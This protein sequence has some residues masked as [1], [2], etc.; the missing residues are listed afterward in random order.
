[1]HSLPQTRSTKIMSTSSFSIVDTPDYKSDD[2]YVPDSFKHI[3]AEAGA[4]LEKALSAEDLALEQQQ[5]EAQQLEEKGTN[6]N[7]QNGIQD[8]KQDKKPTGVLSETRDC[9]YSR[10][11][12][13]TPDS[14]ILMDTY[15][16][17]PSM[18]MSM[19][20]MNDTSSISIDTS[21]NNNSNHR[22]KSRMSKQTPMPFQSPASDIDGPYDV[23]LGSACR[24]NPANLYN[25]NY[26]A[27]M[28]AMDDQ[29][30]VCPDHEDDCLCHLQFKF[31]PMNL[32]ERL[33]GVKVDDIE[34]VVGVEAQAMERASRNDNLSF[35]S[36][37]EVKEE[38]EMEEK[39]EANDDDFLPEASESP[40]VALSIDADLSF[41][42]SGNDDDDNDD[43]KDDNDNILYGSS[44]EEDFEEFL[45]NNHRSSI[46]SGT[47]MSMDGA[48][49]RKSGAFGKAKEKHA[50]APALAVESAVRVASAVAP[51]K[52]K[53]ISRKGNN[54]KPQDDTKRKF[55]QWKSRGTPQDVNLPAS[56]SKDVNPPAS[57][58]KDKTNNKARKFNISLPFPRS[59]RMNSKRARQY[60]LLDKIDNNRIDVPLKIEW[61]EKREER[62][63]GPSREHSRASMASTSPTATA[64]TV[65]SP[66]RTSWR[67]RKL[68]VPKAP[69]LLTRN[70]RGER[71]YSTASGKQD[72]IATSLLENNIKNDNKNGKTKKKPYT[73]TVPKEPRLL[74][75][76]KMGERKYSTTGSR[77]KVWK[78]LEVVTE[79]PIPK[80]LGKRPLTVPV[81]P[82]LVMNQK[83]G[84]KRYSTAG[85]QNEKIVSPEKAQTNWVNRKPT[86]PKPP[87]LSFFIAEPRKRDARK[88]V[89]KE[90]PSEPFVF[91][92]RPAPNFSTPS[93]HKSNVLARPLTIPRPFRLTKNER[94]V[95]APTDPSTPMPLG[96]DKTWAQ[97]KKETSPPMAFRARPVPNFT[98]FS[99]P[100]RKVSSRPLTVPKPFHLSTEDRANS[101]RR[102][103]ASAAVVDGV[104]DD[105]IG[106]GTAIEKEK[107]SFVFKAR[108]VPNYSKEYIPQQRNSSRRITVPKPFHLTLSE[109]AS[110]RTSIRVRSPTLG[111]D[112]AADISNAVEER[113]VFRARSMPSSRNPNSHRKA[114]AKRAL[115]VPVPF[116]LG[117]ADSAN[118]PRRQFIQPTTSSGETLRAQF[119]SPS[120]KAPTSP[121]PFRFLT[122][123]RALVRKSPSSRSHGDSEFGL[124]PPPETKRVSLIGAPNANGSQVVR[125]AKKKLTV[126]KPFRLTPSNRKVSEGSKSTEKEVFSFRARPMPSYKPS[127]QQPIMT[128]R[129]T[130]PRPFRLRTG[131]RA[132]IEDHGELKAKLFLRSKQSAVARAEQFDETLN[133]VDRLLEMSSSILST[134]STNPNICPTGTIDGMSFESES[135]N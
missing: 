75:K 58:S 94:A 43:M 132:K 83:F 33:E 122:E 20:S 46:M 81:S 71:R 29:P 32:Q 42:P 108:P 125:L 25:T 128:K 49:K 82:N 1:M 85:V 96:I 54:D 121:Q 92:A 55:R 68:T 27:R 26:E 107:E 63:P 50:A 80:T 11:G 89:Q 131:E 118:S 40:I 67:S 116:R 47:R 135:F 51:A 4:N 120:K 106:K 109:R 19:N 65:K 37:G 69:N 44:E 31:L 91:K 77:S 24:P 52:S 129:L 14:S 21:R 39:E 18:N 95:S 99:I 38:Q 119:P 134:D 60:T 17:T 45:P 93:I 78:T 88:E 113:F 59:P 10:S 124:L 76:E 72:E 3:F 62:T 104:V 103:R 61:S 48:S 9:E 35:A 123:E 112:L 133:T 36:E 56:P 111:N 30:G 114:L 5:Q 66:S 100:Q 15:M 73:A 70:K 101:P 127:I 23:E 115:T 84:E 53:P 126:P 79:K 130:S 74:S 105:N 41:G 28:Q 110:S 87:M 117:T 57:P 102:S 2:E 22:N 8:D 34:G 98:Q 97:E 7:N 64:A 6:H 86:V 13:I 16:E 12:E 90:Q